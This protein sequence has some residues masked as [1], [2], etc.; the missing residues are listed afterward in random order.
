[1]SDDFLV[2][3]QRARDLV[4]ATGE[5]QAVYTKGKATA[6]VPF[7]TYKRLPKPESRV[8][9]CLVRRTPAYRKQQFF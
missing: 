2:M 3:V 7:A 8:L 1:M 9:R 6:V 5:T 4:D